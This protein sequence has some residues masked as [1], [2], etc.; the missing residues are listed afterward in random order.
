MSREKEKE[1]VFALLKN[2]TKIKKYRISNIIFAVLYSGVKRAKASLSSF[3]SFNIF[4]AFCYKVIDGN[5]FFCRS[6][7]SLLS[8]V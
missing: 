3:S 5:Q 8:V 7:H 2:K 1:A 4:G 6:Y